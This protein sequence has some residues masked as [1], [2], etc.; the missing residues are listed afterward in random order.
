MI[1][2]WSLLRDFEEND[3]EEALRN[4]GLGFVMGGN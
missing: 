3:I 1:L 4:K 2:N